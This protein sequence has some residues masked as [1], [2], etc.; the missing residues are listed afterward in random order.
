MME[1]FG[2]LGSVMLAFCG[3]PQAIESYKTKNSDGLTWGFL[4]M[5]L[6]GEVFTFIFIFPTMILPLVFNYTA[7][8]IFVGIIIY[9]KIRP[10]RN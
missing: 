1:I 5:W 8:L 4:L 9:Y 10:T 6:F 7:N 2:W 3:L